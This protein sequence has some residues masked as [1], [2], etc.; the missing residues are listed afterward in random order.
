MTEYTPLTYSPVVE[1]HGEVTAL[2]VLLRRIAEDCGGYL[3]VTRPIRLKRNEMLKESELVR[4]VLLA[5]MRAGQHGVVLI[6][7]DG[8][9]DCPVELAKNVQSV[10]SK[11]HIECIIQV[12]VAVREYES[13]FLCSPSSLSSKGLVHKDFTSE[14]DPEKIRGAKEETRRMLKSGVYKETQDQASLTAQFSI[15]EGLKNCR[16]FRKLHKSVSEALEG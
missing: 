7:L 12:V 3:N 5:A 9:D 15:E 8:D 14:R 6:L 2:P 1:G 11:A 16:W 10:A 4:A 13:L